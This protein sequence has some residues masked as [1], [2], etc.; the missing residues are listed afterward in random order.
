MHAGSPASGGPTALRAAGGSG[1][2]P[3]VWR[4]LRAWPRSIRHS[5][6]AIR[7]VLTPRPSQGLCHLT[8]LVLASP[9]ASV[10][11]C[12]RGPKTA[13]ARPLVTNPRTLYRVA[14]ARAL[15]P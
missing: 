10:T 8:V 9:S 4:K 3:Q 1:E 15:H 11:P 13:S 12:Q 5:R 2:R 7:S 6:R 14:P